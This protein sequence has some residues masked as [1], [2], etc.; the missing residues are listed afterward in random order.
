MFFGMGERFLDLW[1]SVTAF[2]CLFV[3]VVKRR[4]EAQVPGAVMQNTKSGAGLQTQITSGKC[5][6]TVSLAIFTAWANPED[7]SKG[8]LAWDV[9]AGTQ[10]GMEV[11]GGMTGLERTWEVL[12]DTSTTRSN[13]YFTLNT[14]DHN[15][16]SFFWKTSSPRLSFLANALSSTQSLK[17]ES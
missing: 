12:S 13:R 14:K 6:E 3:F 7:Q 11:A 8:C 5:S 1:R 17:Q 16:L 9:Y 15:S 4:L 2:F 10:E